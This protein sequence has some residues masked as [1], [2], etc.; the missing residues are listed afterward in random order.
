MPSH[1]ILLSMDKYK[2]INSTCPEGS[3]PVKGSIGQ[4]LNMFPQ[5]GEYLGFKHMK[6]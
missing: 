4:P 1:L 6:K 3:Y 2:Q 5:L